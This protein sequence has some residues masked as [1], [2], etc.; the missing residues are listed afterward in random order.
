M[1]R[2]VFVLWNSILGLWESILGL[3]EFDPKYDFWPLWS[4]FGLRVV[5][6]I[7]NL[8]YFDVWRVYNDAIQYLEPWPLLWAVALRFAFAVR[9]SNCVW[10]FFHLTTFKRTIFFVYDFVLT[11]LLFFI[12]WRGLCFRLIVKEVIRGNRN[13][14]EFALNTSPSP[15]WS[16]IWLLIRG[17]GGYL[18]RF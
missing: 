14:V 10:L 9:L 5:L 8:A 13:T 17:G 11:L 6:Y 15:S 4:D 2:M 18:R 3:L 1:N 7:S 16:R 12:R